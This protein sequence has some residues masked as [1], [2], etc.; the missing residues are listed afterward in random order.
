MTRRIAIIGAGPGGIC[1]GIKLR[2]AGFDDF[3]IFERAPGVGGVWYHNTYPGAACDVQSA[4]YSFSFELK[5]DWSR[6]YATQPEIRAYFEHCVEAYGLAPHIRLNTRVS[7]AHW[8]DERSEWRVITE[9]GVTD[10]LD[11]GGAARH[12]EE[13]LFDVVIGAVGMFNELHVPDIAGL[14]EFR[15]TRFHSARWDHSHDLSGERVAVVGSAASA[16]QFVPEI[17]PGVERLHV[18]QRT[19]NWVLP[20]LDTPY[21][22]DE[23]E[24]FRTD[25]DAIVE[26]RALVWDRLDGFITFSNPRAVRKAQEWGELNLAVVEDAALRRELTPD[27][28]HGCKRPLVSNEW[29]PTF[30]RPN[31]ELVTR[32]IERVTADAIVTVDGATRA[33]DTIVLATGFDTTKYL[34]VVD[35]TGRDDRRLADAWSD[36]ARAYLGLTTAGFPNLFMLYGPNTNNGSIL[37]MIECQVGYVLRHLHRMDTHGL[38]S[39]DVRVDVMDEYNHALQDDLDA[40]EVWNAGC[41]GYYRGPTGRIVTQWPHTMTEYQGRTDRADFDAYDSRAARNTRRQTAR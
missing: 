31:V 3:T 19:P 26:E 13:H 29:F 8:D 32:P 39:I 33:V 10:H 4:L 16:V 15:G 17:A 38:A 40:V 27:F 20:K 6:P 9:P 24:R 30:N 18:F 28:P 1:M 23:L 41:N 14:D 25:P 34:S 2:E 22:D 12:A 11:T 7:A 35:V 21:T 36:G 5:R 37:F